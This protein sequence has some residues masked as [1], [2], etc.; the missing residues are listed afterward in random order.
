MSFA[1]AN[2][3]AA[4]D[5]VAAES[6]HDQVAQ[7]TNVWDET[8]G[9]T[10][11]QPDH[12]FNTIGWN[13]S[14][15]GQPIPA[16]EM[17]SWVED[18][19]SRILALSPRRVLEIGCG[20][21][22]LLFRIAPQ[23]EQYHATD[24]SPRALNHIAQHV[25]DRH[26][27]TL[28][29]RSADDFE[30]L[31]PESFDTVILNSVVQYFPDVDYL[32]SVLTAAVKTVK[33]GSVFLGDIRNL[34]LLEAFH[35]S[36]VLAN[37]S[38]TTTAANCRRLVQERMYGEEELFIDPDFFYALKQQLPE[39]TSVEIQLKRGWYHNELTRFRYDVILHVGQESSNGFDRQQLDWQ[40]DGLS[41]A[42]LR[43]LLKESAPDALQ[44][45]RVPNLRVVRELQAAKHL[46]EDPN[47]TAREIKA[48]L[49]PEGAI[50]PE[51]LWALA[52][53][54]Y[55]VAITW[56]ETGGCFD[57]LF[58][59]DETIRAFETP[60]A[61][62][63]K[64]LRD[65]ANDPLQGLFMRK[66]VPSLRAYLKDN[67]PDYMVPATFVLL[68]KLPL[69]PNGKIDRRALPEPVL[70]TTARGGTFIAPRTQTEEMVAGIWMRV[71]GVEQ[72]GVED[73]FFELGGHS[74][75][76]TQIVTRVRA[77]FK[78][79]LPLRLLFEKPTVA[80][81]ALEIERIIRE[82]HGVLAPPIERVAATANLPL[83]FAQ[84][85]LWFLD[86]LTPDNA[87][88]NMQLG[89]RLNGEL[90]VEALTAALNEICRRH[91][92]FRASFHNVAGDPVQTVSAP[93]PFTL[94][95]FDLSTSSED[96][97]E[98]LAR[99]ARAELRQPF[100]LSVAPLVRFSLFKTSERE[101]VLLK[102][103]HHI[104]SDGWSLSIFIGELAVLYR[105]YY[106][107]KPSPLPE[108][109]IQY[110]D[111]ARWQTE[112]LKGDVLH[113]HLDY[114]KKQLAGIPPTLELRTDR[115]RPA[116][117]TY[118]GARH[119]FT[120][121]KEVLEAL[122]SMSKAEGMT[123]FMTLLAAWLTLLSRYSGQEDICVGTPMANRNQPETEG[124]IG[125]F[126]DTLLLRGDVS[127]NPTFR[128]LMGRV[129]ETALGAY[130]HQN[131]PFEKLVDEL[132]PQRD[133][134][135]NP[136]F[137]VMFTV[138]KAADAK[139]DTPGIAIGAVAFGADSTRF[140]LECQF[141][142]ITH[143]LKGVNHLQSRLIRCDDDSKPGRPPPGVVGRD[144]REPRSAAFRLAAVNS[145]RG[146]AP[147][148][149]V[150]PDG[151]RL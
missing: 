114:W 46:S 13:S 34:R 70:S 143:E 60:A 88:Y 104:I 12:T 18:T 101:H 100:D 1:R 8:Y 16:E 53:S 14:Y 38:D 133:T 134:S 73:N 89:I 119:T 146:A 118:R 136:L 39:I 98:E 28:A 65:F 26:H 99:I 137:Q 125:F 121:K 90:S 112:W 61:P 27:V 49:N 43:R 57:V 80:S 30:G 68:D 11:V 74:L 66:I 94:D 109:P 20:T 142:D 64:S 129:R 15:S 47:L 78:I 25:D 63:F 120:V 85:R 93:Q 72:L 79:D 141:T 9:Q 37:S 56:S 91:E 32:A 87:F 55:H 135:R 52:E 19:V 126:V 113:Q 124:L 138:N 123:L 97:L 75:L 83:S 5:S 110:S 95:F 44:V 115:P 41:P 105:S 128:T 6:R 151:H 69:T 7:W 17:Q 77:S 131:I 92:V 10:P 86:Q 116:L 67:L 132:Q 35:T 29:Q 149:R 51:N 107:H 96:P 50:D 81:L 82:G 36:V 42:S 106:E 148:E 23:T 108:L 71:L 144:R 59:R 150:E 31:E 117:P 130:A 2:A 48:A 45:T 147:G 54:G 58:S 62:G 21:G 122:K 3:M 103:M 4:E 33:R 24:V 76:A 139:L 22:L 111:F 127:G 102:T 145:G 140:D 40:T 84:Q